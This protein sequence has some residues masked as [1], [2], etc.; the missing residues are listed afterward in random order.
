[1]TG[2]SAV[3][4]ASETRF[5]YKL[6]QPVE[7]KDQADL[8]LPISPPADTLTLPD[9][10]SV[11]GSWGGLD[12]GKIS[13][14]VNN[15]PRPYPESQVLAVT[16]G[17]GL[18]ALK[19]IEPPSVPSEV[20]QQVSLGQ[21]IDQVVAILGQPSSIADL[22]SKKIYVFKN[23]KVTFIEGKVTDME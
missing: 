18:G 21:S 6:T 11:T 3:K 20:T 7:R 15:Q 12:A 19:P 5:T 13:F 4:I 9:G 14:Q 22:G 16:F 10:K 2:K 23:L 8:A 1:L 17:P